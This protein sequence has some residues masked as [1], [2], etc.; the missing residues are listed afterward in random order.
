MNQVAAQAAPHNSPCSHFQPHHPTIQTALLANMT[1][2]QLKSV[3]ADA[4]HA[5]DQ[6]AA[7]AIVRFMVDKPLARQ[8]HGCLF[9]GPPT[10]RRI[11]TVCGEC[12]AL[13]ASLR[14]DQ[15]KTAYRCAIEFNQSRKARAIRKFIEGAA[16]DERTQ[17]KHQRPAQRTAPLR[18]AGVGTP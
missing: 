18:M 11:E 13:L 1:Q 15:L 12:V 9:C 17:T 3:Y 16:T 7:A 4:M 2:N 6:A 5:G 14:Q 10:N 8:T